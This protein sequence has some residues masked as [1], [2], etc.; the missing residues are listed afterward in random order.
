MDVINGTL[1]KGSQIVSA[2]QDMNGNDLISWRKLHLRNLYSMSKQH[3]AVRNWLITV[4][5]I[6]SR[7][8]LTIRG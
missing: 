6:E 8:S 3:W 2:M 4:E 1:I 5:S 7:E